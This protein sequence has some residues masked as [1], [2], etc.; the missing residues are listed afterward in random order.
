MTIQKL[1]KEEGL[2]EGAGIKSYKMGHKADCEKERQIEKSREWSTFYS[3]VN[4]YT[5]F[6]FH[7][8]FKTIKINS[9]ACFGGVMFL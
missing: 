5:S 1:K 9:K 8:T 4:V 2:R 6:L 3:L 7:P